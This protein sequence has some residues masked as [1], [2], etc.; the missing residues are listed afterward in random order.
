MLLLSLTINVSAAAVFETAQMKYNRPPSSIGRDNAAL[1][2]DLIGDPDLK[3]TVVVTCSCLCR[4]YAP[5]TCRV[6]VGS[7]KTVLW[8]AGGRVT[9]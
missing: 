2:R 5:C 7:A 3:I 4:S 1:E 9:V 6:C 8:Y